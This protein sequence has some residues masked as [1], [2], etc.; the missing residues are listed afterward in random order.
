MKKRI[1]KQFMAIVTLAIL[2]SLF[3]ISVLNYDLFREQVFE[4]LKTFAYVVIDTKGSDA[5]AISDFIQNYAGHDR[6]QIRITLINREGVVLADSMAQAV[7]MVDHSDRKEVIEAWQHGTGEAVRT[8]DTIHESAYYVAVRIDDNLVLRVSTD[9]N[10]IYDIFFRAIPMIVV[11]AVAL[12]LLCMVLA[13]LLTAGFIK[14]IKDLAEGI[15]KEEKAETYEELQPFMET[16]RKQHENILHSAQ[17]R[18]EFT[19]NVSH[20]LK[21]PLT[22]I[23]GYSELIENGMANVEETRRFAGEI[24]KN[25]QRLLSL[26]NDTLELAEL[27]TLSGEL[28]VETVN[29]YE[30]AQT[31]ADMLELQAKKHG[32]TIQ[33]DGTPAY[34]SGNRQML[35]EVVYNLCDNAIRYNKENGLVQIQVQNQADAVIF[36]VADTGIGISEEYHSRVFERFFRVD[37]S[38]SKSTGGTGLGLAIVKHIVA[39]HG[40]TLELQSREHIGTEITVTFARAAQKTN[41]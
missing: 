17:M 10:S 24:H 2:A 22:A 23:S 27:D 14:P 20:E 9:G 29:L 3:L 7:S 30:L 34:V 6:D 38:R 15:G 41:S 37:K 19:A 35:E 28:Q 1:Q 33:V 21:T 11:I 5:E 26:I 31:C 12:W 16:I 4:K 13:K 25:A 39:I 8:S 40:A 18:Q 36:R 32:V